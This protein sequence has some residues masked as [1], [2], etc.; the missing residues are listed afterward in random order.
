LIVCCRTSEEDVSA[1][2]R[3][4]LGRRWGT[5]D[6]LKPSPISPLPS[7]GGAVPLKSIMK[8]PKTLSDETLSSTKKGIS[9]S[10]DT[11]FK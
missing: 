4:A 1:C 5:V 2:G 7:P 6:L 10:H 9:F 11:V 3:S 8:S